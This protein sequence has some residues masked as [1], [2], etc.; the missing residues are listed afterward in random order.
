MVCCCASRWSCTHRR[1]GIKA[2]FKP[3][4][5]FFHVADPRDENA[6]PRRARPGPEGRFSAPN[7]HR[8]EGVFTLR[9]DFGRS[10]TGYISALLT[11][12]L[13]TARFS[14]TKV[15]IERTIDVDGLV[16]SPESWSAQQQMYWSRMLRAAQPSRWPWWP[17]KAH[18]Y[19][20]EL[21]ELMRPQHAQPLVV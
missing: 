8:R 19:Q 2:S 5:L 18:L 9:T 7:T 16:A 12:L 13:S 4:E 11:T 1:N 3:A 14:F 6:K 20:R 17:Q 10:T 21:T 15:R